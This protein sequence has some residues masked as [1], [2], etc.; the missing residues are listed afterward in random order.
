MFFA[1]LSALVVTFLAS[2]YSIKIK[3]NYKVIRIGVGFFIPAAF[4][5]IS[6]GTSVLHYC[7]T[8]FE[9]Y[10]EYRFITILKSNSSREKEVMK[11]LSF[12]SLPSQISE[13]GIDLFFKQILS[14]ELYNSYMSEILSKKVREKTMNEIKE[15]A[16]SKKAQS[17]KKI[18][19][20]DIFEYIRDRVSLSYKSF[21]Y[22][23]AFSVVFYIC[24]NIYVYLFLQQRHRGH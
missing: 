8:E 15:L 23:I 5:S 17:F 24:C 13:T 9:L 18:K 11:Y 20:V 10:S 2:V 19:E 4:F 12:A 7:K 21:I 3:N 6:M 14:K 1:A 22:C 16:I